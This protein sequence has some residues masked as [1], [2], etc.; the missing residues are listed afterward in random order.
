MAKSVVSFGLS[1]LPIFPKEP[2]MGDAFGDAL[3]DGDAHI[4][5]GIIRQFGVLHGVAH[6]AELA[7]RKPAI[8]D[9]VPSQVHGVRVNQNRNKPVR[10]PRPVLYTNAFFVPLDGQLT[11]YL[12]DQGIAIRIAPEN[13]VGIAVES[14]QFTG[15]FYDN[16]AAKLPMP[17]VNG[18]LHFRLNPFASGF[19]YGVGAGW[20]EDEPT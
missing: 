14:G 20:H 5:H 7:K 4:Q 19:V 10:R 15:I 13:E 12:G 16:V 1:E 3:G 17:L 11:G 2:C 18:V 6:V 9:N 8:D